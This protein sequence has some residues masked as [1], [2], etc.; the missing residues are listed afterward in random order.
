[1]TEKKPKTVL[2]AYKETLDGTDRVKYEEKLKIIGGNGSYQLAHFS[3][4]VKLLPRVTYPVPPARSNII[5]VLI[6][7]YVCHHYH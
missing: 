5:I 3:E 6:Y 1:M 4:D 2:V 7:V